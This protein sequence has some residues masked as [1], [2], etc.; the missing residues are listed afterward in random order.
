MKI[1]RFKFL[2]FQI[3]GQKSAFFGFFY[4]IWAKMAISLGLNGSCMVS[5]ESSRSCASFDHKYDHLRQ[6]GRIQTVHHYEK[7]GISWEI[8]LSVGSM[9][10]VG[11]N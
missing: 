5:I 2:R 10:A 7:Y 9:Y 8:A 4:Y 3:L 1:V 6:L 11:W